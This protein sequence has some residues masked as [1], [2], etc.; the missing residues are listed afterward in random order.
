MAVEVWIDKLNISSVVP[1]SK[2]DTAALLVLMLII[3]YCDLQCHDILAELH[4]FPTLFIICAS[5]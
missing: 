5:S 1:T 4:E 3:I 2:A